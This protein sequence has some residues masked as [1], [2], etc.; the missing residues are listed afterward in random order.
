MLAAADLPSTFRAADASSL[1]GQRAAVRWRATQL[2]LLLAAAVAG[3]LS[4]Q[5]TARLD[6]AT[7][8]AAGAYA[9]ALVCERA[10]VQRNPEREWYR[11]RAGA[12]SVKTLAWKYAVGGEPFVAGAPDADATFHDS[13]RGVTASLAEVDWISDDPDP[14]QITPA[15]REL[16]AAPLAERR[17]AYR[18]DRIADQR[19]WYAGNAAGAR[20]GARRWSTVVTVATS[21]GLI[22]AAVKAFGGPGLNFLGVASACAA[23]A[24]AWTQFRQH[25]SLASAYGVAARELA[26]IEDQVAG[27]EDETT[28]ARLVKESEEAISRE[29]TMWAARRDIRLSR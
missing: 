8:A 2:M 28:W 9:A 7:V 14:V 19:A 23:A 29:H 11:G 6:L 16:R 5:L 21:I 24:A 1:A 17:E 3:V 20:R 27:C 22:G 25:E 18:R 12:E 13:L 10:R 4:W 26:L 15:M